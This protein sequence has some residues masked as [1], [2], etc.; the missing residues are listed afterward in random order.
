MKKLNQLNRF[1]TISKKA[2]TAINGGQ[3]SGW[4]CKDDTGE[5]WD[6]ICDENGNCSWVKRGT[7]ATIGMY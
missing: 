1:K 3:G 2:Q 5:C 6:W 7:S 4:L